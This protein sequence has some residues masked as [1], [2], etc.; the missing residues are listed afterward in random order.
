MLSSIGQ[1]LNKLSASCARFSDVGGAVATLSNPPCLKFLVSKSLG[2]AIVAGSSMVKFPQ[3]AKIVKAGTVDGLSAP[4]IFLEM[5]STI[6]S[7]AYYYGLN[8]PF[9]T[10][11]ENF[12]LLLQNV[13][14]G[15]LYFH[16]TKSLG[17]KS[18]RFVVS[19]ALCAAFGIV[20]YRRALPA[21]DV[22]PAACAALGLA[23][24]KVTCE[25][26]CGVLPIAIM[27]VGRLP[28]IAQ[29][30]KQGHAG[31]LAFAT[32]LLNVAG[33]GARVFTV[34]QELDDKLALTAAVSSCLQN[35]VLVAQILTMGCAPAAGAAAAPKK[36]APKGK[37]T[38][39]AQ[40]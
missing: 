40:D 9:S 39:K 25:Q 10:W 24:C 6:A 22:P 32:Y 27:L 29:N 38:K 31:Q 28:Q 13:A 12:F 16:Y 4:S 36:A 19:A 14:I 17:V 5:I 15:A 30:F 21:V 11:G 33:S 18:A 1:H 2:Y 3:I 35:F 37:K 8:Y 7:F 34:M 26:I 23:S 20:L